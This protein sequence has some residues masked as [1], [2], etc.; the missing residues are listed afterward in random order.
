METRC[1][2]SAAQLGRQID[3]PPTEDKYLSIYETVGP[4]AGQIFIDD[5]SEML[6]L[7]PSMSQLRKA[8]RKQEIDLGR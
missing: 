1:K 5:R 6:S 7:A 4:T 3:S 2:K 8:Q